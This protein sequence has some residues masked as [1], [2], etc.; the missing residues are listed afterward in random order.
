MDREAVNK[1]HRVSKK[2]WLG[3]LDLTFKINIQDTENI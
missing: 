3:N 1:F 2:A